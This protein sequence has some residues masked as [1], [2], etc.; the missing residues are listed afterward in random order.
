[1]T[2]AEIRIL[3]V[4]GY[5]TFGGR[6]VELLVH[7]LALGAGVVQGS[8]HVAVGE[9]VLVGQA[10]EVAVGMSVADKR[11]RDDRE[12]AVV[13]AQGRTVSRVPA[14]PSRNGLRPP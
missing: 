9:G 12:M 6:L 14:D 11:Q 3:I 7:L 10:E 2:A 4:G 5:G 13:V 1:M 8:V